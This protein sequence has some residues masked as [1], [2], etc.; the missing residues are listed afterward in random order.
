[1]ACYRKQIPLLFPNL[2]H[3]E[4]D[5]N[6]KRTSTAELLKVTTLKTFANQVL[7]K[8]TILTEEVKDLKAT[9]VKN[10]FRNMDAVTKHLTTFPGDQKIIT[11]TDHAEQ[12]A[13]LNNALDL[14]EE[15]IRKELAAAEAVTNNMIDEAK[16][17]RTTCFVLLHY[18]L[19]TLESDALGLVKAQNPKIL[20]SITDETDV[21]DSDHSFLQPDQLPLHLLSTAFTIVDFFPSH[22]FL[23]G[24]HLRTAMSISDMLYTYLIS[25]FSPQ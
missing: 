19:E 9:K 1:M 14:A 15:H 12:I 8:T 23:S 18:L 11:N 24:I 2:V 6:Y 4:T 3:A 13:F 22:V 16:K 21:L 7:A 5:L 10:K 25:K 20:N 17:I